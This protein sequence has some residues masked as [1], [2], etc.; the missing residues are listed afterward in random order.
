M[1]IIPHV[2]VLYT[3]V[4][5][6]FSDIEEGV[7]IDCTMGYGGHSSMILEA[8][9][10]IKLIAID[11]D[12]TAI[13]FSTKRLE[14]YRDRVEIK[15]GRFSSV[16]KEILKEYDIKDIRGI[17][18]DIGV[19]SLQLDQKER[20]FSFASENLDMR[21]DKDAPL[22]AAEV[23][24][25]YS[26]TDLER[27]LLEY[28]ELRN[29]K[30]IA[31]FIVSNRPFS[32]AQELSEAVTHLMPKGKK[33]HPATLLMQAIRIEVNNELGELSSL[34]DTIEEAKF[35]NAKIAIISFH[36]LEDR[37]V[38]NRF[39]KWSKSCICPPEAM[40]CTCGNNHSYGRVLT[41]K[42][43]TAEDDELKANPRSRSAKLR[44]FETDAEQ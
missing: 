11:Q 38:K 10:N 29:Y 36:S 32:S 28:G 24:N 42:P 21:M 3:Q 5:D 8:N 2:P 43:I 35:P 18:A 33:I 30:K 4:L 6:T 16:I 40:R 27:I 22:S 9:P 23:V 13:D 25:E 26:Q 19:S 15:K 34:L 7:I 37:I 20:G 1:Q 41:K 17:L 39:S 31:S 12:Q 44:V 14:P